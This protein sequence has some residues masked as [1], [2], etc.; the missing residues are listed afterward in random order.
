MTASHPEVDIIS[1]GEH[2]R[3]T[4]GRVAYTCVQT[5]EHGHHLRRV[6]DPEMFE[7]FSHAEMARTEKSRAYR[8]DKDW[9]KQGKAKARDRSGVENFHDIPRREQPKVLWKWEYCDRFR[10]MVLNGKADR[11]NLGMTQAIA[12]IAVDV[13]RLDCAKIARRVDEKRPKGKPVPLKKDGTPH[14]LRCAT[15]VEYREPPSYRTLQR[16]LAVLENCDW[17]IEALRDN[18]RNC[19]DRSPRLEPEAHELMVKTA[20]GYASQARRSRILQ[21]DLLDAAIVATNEQRSAAGLPPL[22]CPSKRR[23]YAEIASLDAFWVYARRHTLKAAELKFAGV[24]DGP[25]ATRIGQRIEMDEWQVSLQTL[26]VQTG[27]WKLLTR[28]QK[29]LVRRARWWLYVAIDRASRCILAM[30]L[31]E[32]PRA[33]E[34]VASIRMI[35]SDKS[36][37]SDATGAQTP[38]SMA[39]GIGLLST[40][41]GSAFRS[42]ECRRV[43]RAMGATFSPPP[44]KRPQLRGTIER[45]FLTL[46]TRFMPN[47]AGRTFSN[48][49]QKGDYDPEANA[50]IPLEV[51][52]RAVVRHVA[53]D[54]HNRPHSGLGGETPANAWRRLI[55]L[56]G[57]FPIPDRQTQ[58][59]IFGVETTCTLDNSGVTVLGL[60]YQNREL[61][62]WFTHHGATRVL[63]RCDEE[64]VGE[65]SVKLGDDW[66][67]AP[68]L[69]RELN[70]ISLKVWTKSVLEL[71]ARFKNE[72]S[73]SRP[74]VLA[75]VRDLDAI[76]RE[77]AREA[78]IA[79]ELDTPETLWAARERLGLGFALPEW[80]EAA[81]TDDRDL[82]DDVIPAC[83]PDSTTASAAA[84]V[85]TPSPEQTSLPAWRMGDRNEAPK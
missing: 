61:Y 29:K 41:W 71:R 20:R 38:W 36:H 16:W 52:A 6:D 66:V 34:A 42:E 68:C 24:E 23:F 5:T 19:G 55:K 72:A 57:R 43:V 3:I 13:N 82:L 84:R 8:F 60:R 2:D 78:G 83:I 80:D 12:E 18:Y 64:D 46:E 69:K 15:A 31:V 25:T 9:F 63:V 30:R 76:G 73:L 49:V 1:Y 14:K 26:L 10:E 70:G 51:L 7:T 39:T 40:D 67:A 75:T 22:I 45:M 85:D 58:R 47:F 59:A 32:T 4:I 62:D 11:S 79:E 50:T 35:L 65:V 27:A 77:H 28:D 33:S 81:A 37:L 21:Y 17:A 53:D 48:V 56:A 74:I 54:Y 44:T